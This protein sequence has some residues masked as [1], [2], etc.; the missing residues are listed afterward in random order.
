MVADI[1]RVAFFR[2]EYHVA[3]GFLRKSLG[4]DVTRD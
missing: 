3:C 2:S 4:L 1:R